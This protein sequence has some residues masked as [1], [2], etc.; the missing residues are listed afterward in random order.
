M[1][2]NEMVEMLEAYKEE[3]GGDAEVRIMSQQ[4]WPF[5]NTVHG[6]CS[7]FEINLGDED[8]D[9]NISEDAVVYIVEGQ[10]LG[11]GSKRAWDRCNR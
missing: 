8:D 11:Y 5:E 9:S 2:L 1:T 6:I 7:G 3:F 10:Q 4:N